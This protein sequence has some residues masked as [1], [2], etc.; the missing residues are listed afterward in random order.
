MKA[1][2]PFNINTDQLVEL[3][4]TAANHAVTHELVSDIDLFSQYITNLIHKAG[5]RYA[6]GGY[7]EH[8]T[9]YSRSQVFD[10]VDSGGEPRRLHLGTDIW[11]EAGTPVTAP[12]DA[13][14]H[15]VGFHETYGDYG[16]VI[17]LQHEWE[18]ERIHSLYG[19]LSLSSITGVKPGQV[20]AAGQQ[21]AWFGEPKE[22][23]HWPPHVHF[24][25]I[26]DMQGYSGDYPGVCRFSE[27]DQYLANCP[28][29]M[30]WLTATF[31]R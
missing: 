23:G 24:Q 27:R 4:L 26:K 7:N 3:D 29:P 1:I 28:D 9:V 2:V 11:G 6:I 18:G 8:R 12:V 31:G 20:I 25:L 19:H 5:A 30:P 21:F 22:N 16:A 17:I 13:V 14:V 10:G 15:S